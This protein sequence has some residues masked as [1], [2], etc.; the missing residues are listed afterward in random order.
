MSATPAPRGGGGPAAALFRHGLKFGVSAALMILLLR[1]ISLPDLERL[2]RTLDPAMLAAATAVFVVSNVAGWFQWHVLL[3]ASGINAGHARTFGFYNVGL[4][5]NNFLPANIGGDA[6]KVYDVTRLGASV[7][8]V[9]AVTLLD[10]L[11]GVFSLCLLAT[12]ADLFLI[13]RSPHPYGYY[14]IVFVACM[15]PAAGFYFFRPLGHAL[16]RLALRVRPLALDRRITSV[17]DHLSPFKGRRA[18]VARLVAFSMLIQALRVL[19]HVLVGLAMGIS[20][21]RMV[22]MQFFVFVPLLSLAMIP[23]VTINGLGVREGLGILLFALAGIGRTD[24]FALEFVTYIISVL[25]S[26]VGLGFFLARR[27][28]APGPPPFRP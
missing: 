27:A 21:D 8:Q 11:L 25:A 14:L 23:P 17:L 22:L 28:A 20:L 13:P 5:F 2:L 19:T 15:V 16:R 4:F 3:R 9:I 1:K 6:V 24:A 10:R 7:Y 18:L 12:V 26:L